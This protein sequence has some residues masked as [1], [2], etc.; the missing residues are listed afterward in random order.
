MVERQI[1]FKASLQLGRVTKLIDFFRTYLV[2]NTSGDMKR[3]DDLENLHSVLLVD[4]T[5][6]VTS[7]HSTALKPL[8]DFLYSFK[9]N[10]CVTDQYNY[11]KT[12]ET[13]LSTYTDKA[14]ELESAYCELLS[15]N[16]MVTAKLDDL[17]NHS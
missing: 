9:K 7:L 11:K 10:N 15:K 17:E 8:T 14:P 5:G 2:T 12:T 3:P 6:S 16:D 1:C 13:S 4:L